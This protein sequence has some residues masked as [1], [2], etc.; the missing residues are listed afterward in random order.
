MKAQPGPAG[1]RPLARTALFTA[2][3][4]LAMPVTSL[5]SGP[6]LAHTLGPELRGQMAAAVV[7][8]F[9]LMFVAN[10][11]LPEATT[12][13]V[14]KLRQD[15]RVVFLRAA[16]ISVPIGI[17]AAIG[18]WFAAPHIFSAEMQV[19]VP[20]ARTLIWLLP[21]LMMVII[22]RFAVNG[23]RRYRAV[24]TERVL[25]PTLRLLAFA[26]LALIGSLT[27]KSAA[28][29]QLIA[30]VVGGCFLF[31]TLSRYRPKPETL[32][33]T[34]KHLTRTIFGYGLRGWGGVFG[35]L[36]NW[37]LDQLVLVTLVSPLQMGYYVVAVHFSEIPSTAINAVRNVLFAE[38]A[39]RNTPELVARAA[40][41]VLLLVT[42]GG[43]AAGLVAPLVIRWLFGASF[44]PALP[45]ALVLLVAAIP[46]C[47]EQIVAAGLLAQRLPGL[48]SISQLTA[49]VI[50]V[51]GLVVL[52]PIL[53]AMGA[54]LTSLIAYTVNASMAVYQ[55][56]RATGTRA[57]DIVIPRPADARW[58]VGRVRGL[59]AGRRA[60]AAPAPELDQGDDPTNPLM[61][62]AMMPEEYEF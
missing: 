35:N 36:I 15:P 5:M 13:A 32:A 7:P 6:I 11:G 28:L 58:I 16:M 55:L 12:Y 40:R 49:A 61:H 8:A 44:L 48:R 60:K 21:L 56:R 38:T 23:M 47:L 62:P 52:C 39:A 51:I 14:A 27:V 3:S 34:E 37:R 50:T 24:N 22:L 1:R 33:P 20:L 43:L 26:V 2:M 9:V 31:Y 19:A 10:I 18:F 25:T 17:C 4:N 45:M 29:S 46:F 30:T 54:A 57:R 53:G 41:V 59:I 42:A